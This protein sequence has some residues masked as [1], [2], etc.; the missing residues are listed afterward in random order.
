ML[1]QHAAS[2]PVFE[3]LFDNYSFAA[4]NPVSRSMQGVL[5][6]MGIGDAEQNIGGINKSF[7]TENN[8]VNLARMFVDGIDSA[9]G[10]QQIMVDLYDNFFKE[11]FPDVVDKLGIVYTP[12]E[13]VDFI[14]NST[15]EI[16]KREFGRSIADENVHILDPFTGTGTFITRLIQS[17]LLTKDSL[18]R[19]YQSELHANEIMP[20]PYFISSINIE[21]A[22][23]DM[24]GED[25]AY[26]PFDGICLTDTF[27][28]FENTHDHRYIHEKHYVIPGVNAPLHENSE[29]VKGQ[30]KNTIMVIFGNPPYSVGQ[31]DA[32]KNAQN[33]SYP[34]LEDRIR[35]TYAA[36]SNT[37]NKTSLYDSYV[38]AFRWAT[39][40]LDENSD[41]AGIIAYVSNGGWLDGNAMDGMRKCLVDEFSSIYVYNLRGNQ[42]TS[43]ELSQ[44]EGG[45][46]FGSGSRASV[47][48]TFLIRNPSHDG[49]ADIHYYDIG[50]FLTRETK[51]SIV[52]KNH[53]IYQ[54]DWKNINPND[55]GDWL[56]QRND[57]FDTFI[58]IGD[59]KNK[60]NIETCF[61]PVFTHGVLTNR[62]LWN[63]N[64]SSEILISNIKTSIDFFNHEVNLHKTEKDRPPRVCPHSIKWD[65]NLYHKYDCN[66]LLSFD[67]SSARISLCRPFFKQHVYFNKDLNW[68]RYLLPSIF[69]APEIENL[70]ICITGQG[71]GKYF[72]ALITNVIV[73][74][75]FL[76]AA[77]CFPLYNYDNQNNIPESLFSNSKQI[78]NFIRRDAVSD[79][80]LEECKKKYNFDL[81]FLTK[82][83]IFYYFY[84]ILHS[85]DY[86]DM[87]AADLKK[88]LP[89]IPLIQNADDF[90][91]FSKAG[92]SLAKLHLDYE[93]VKPFPVKVTGA[94]T[95]RY[96]VEK[97][98][99][100][101]LP[102]KSVDKSVIQYNSYIRIEGIPLE[103]YKY[104]VSGRSALEW[105]M[106]RYQVTVDME[107]GNRNDP[108]DWAREHD[109]PR[110]ILDLVMRIVTVSLET[111]KIVESLPK[112]DF[113]KIS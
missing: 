49:P 64:S 111:M 99:F 67:D 41:R 80:I 113:T 70:L 37:H 10:R 4:H 25:T 71:T 84:G 7:I 81:R 55:A 16:L 12:I 5:D 76:S 18:P 106:E 60:N 42:R 83:S 45:K 90:I 44:K 43:G 53:D 98:R 78:G 24:M 52:A 62:E 82:Q 68:S 93:T 56:N 29:R 94:D 33:E 36:L 61:Y 104:M 14:I 103:A 92:A 28:L 102:D 2:M 3:A 101:K 34:F 75:D 51:L 79:W 39:E 19:K 21:S 8:K 57:L 95:G 6:V 69:P 23:H 91:A 63:Y 11:A 107:T 88:M 110:Y 54:M 15:A 58:Q 48:I 9:K 86:R 97:M 40:R 47:A 46:I 105:V 35:N 26:R 13:V 87:F 100:G 22:Y 32:N 66:K 20:L 1:A 27:Q 89:K 85:S 50:D 74:H 77:H 108:H 109:Q 30:I 65:Q 73:D 72:S 59:K 96:L 31:D 17:D 112:V 38:K